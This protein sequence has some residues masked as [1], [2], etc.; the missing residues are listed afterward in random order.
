M[1]KANSRI[2]ALRSPAVF[3]FPFDCWRG[4][5]QWNAWNNFRPGGPPTTLPKR[6]PFTAPAVPP[7]AAPAGA[8]RAAPLVAPATLPTMPTTTGAAASE[9]APAEIASVI[10][11]VCSTGAASA[12][13]SAAKVVAQ[14][15]T[16]MQITAESKIS[17]F[18]RLNFFIINLLSFFSFLPPFFSTKTGKQKR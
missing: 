3:L 8:P 17:T 6:A 13:L 18:F 12:V 16:D 2:P 14:N 4:E 15:R 5:F 10:P 9:E 1:Q 11:L 7:I